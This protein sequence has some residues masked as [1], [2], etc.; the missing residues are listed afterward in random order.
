MS[1]KYVCDSKGFCGHQSL[2][3]KCRTHDMSCPSCRVVHFPDKVFI[4][5]KADRRVKF[6][7]EPEFNPALEA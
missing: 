4:S 1:D 7:L 3:G 6:D 2:R 5:V